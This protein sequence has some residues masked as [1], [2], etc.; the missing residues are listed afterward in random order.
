L[1]HGILGAD[2]GIG[3]TYNLLG[4]LYA[5][6]DGAIRAGQIDHARAL[7]DASQIFVES[8]LDLGILPRMKA[9]FRVIGLNL[10]LTRAPTALRAPDASPAFTTLLPAR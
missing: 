4:G 6:L 2:G 9:A 7:R 1:T 10:G 3:T 5:A 8:L